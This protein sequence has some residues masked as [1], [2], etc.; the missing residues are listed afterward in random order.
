MPGEEVQILPAS[1]L[2]YWNLPQSLALGAEG[3]H[4]WLGADSTVSIKKGLSPD[5]FLREWI[6]HFRQ[7]LMRL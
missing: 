4:F 5:R 1:P 2:P 3:G 6:L 7:L